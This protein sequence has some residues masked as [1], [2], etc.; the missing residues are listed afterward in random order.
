M[1]KPSQDKADAARQRRVL[2]AMRRASREAW[3]IDDDLRR[4]CVKQARDT[5]ENDE[6]NVRD[7]QSAAAFV[8]KLSEFNLDRAM[9]MAEI[10]SLLGGEKTPI[11]ILNNKD[12]FGNDAHET[13]EPAD[14]ESP[15]SKI[16]SPGD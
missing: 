11:S 10:D 14:Q 1:D 2:R 5:L 9:L 13:V 8:L 16:E 4:L 12:F 7:R 15:G 6:A 3:D